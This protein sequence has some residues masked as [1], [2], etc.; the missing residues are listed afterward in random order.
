MW[1]SVGMVELVD[2]EEMRDLEKNHVVRHGTVS[3]HECFEDSSSDPSG[4]MVVNVHQSHK[5]TP[6]RQVETG[7]ESSKHDC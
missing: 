7:D 4:T 5:N 3:L 1:G 2:V 6:N